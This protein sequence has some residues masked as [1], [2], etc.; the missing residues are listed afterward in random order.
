[1]SKIRIMVDTSADIPPQLAEQYDIGI[2]NFM[3]NF[4]DESFVAGEEMTNEQFYRRIA[5]TGVHP[6]TAQTPYQDMYDRLF[7]EAKECDTLIYFTISSRASGQYQTAALISKEL[8]EEN[9]DLDIRVVDTQ[10]FSVYIAD[11]AIVAAKAAADGLSADE[12]IATAIEQMKKWEVYLLVDSLEY[13]EKGGRITKTSAI[14][15]T[16]LDIKPVL[17]IREGLIEPLLK[18]RGKKKMFKKLI[19]LIGED[20]CFDAQNPKFIVVHS[21][22]EYADEVCSLLTDEFGADSIYMT[23][24]FGPINGTHTGPGGLAFLISKK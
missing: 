19:D 24:E 1:M 11:A 10:S 3:V 6:K 20:E 12:I 23:S 2:V 14:V 9:P 15:G 4:G 18:I 7:A 13:L 5:E 17:T 16:L 8:C 22:K 21:K